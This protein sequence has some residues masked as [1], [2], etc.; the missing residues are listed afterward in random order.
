MVDF[1]TPRLCSLRPEDLLASLVSRAEAEARARQA[2]VDQLCGELGVRLLR[3]ALSGEA[4]PPTPQE[5]EGVAA[6][7]GNP[8]GRGDEVAAV[9][10]A[11]R[12][13]LAVLASRPL[14]L[15]QI[16]ALAGRSRPA[17]TMALRPRPSTE[18]ALRYIATSP[19]AL[20]P[21]GSKKGTP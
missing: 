5:V 13:R 11:A 6:G 14:T 18:D 21:W 12:G 19:N 2:V 1:V 15:R 4:P 3:F 9:L 7:L 17:V 8:S 20:A 10:D 16:A